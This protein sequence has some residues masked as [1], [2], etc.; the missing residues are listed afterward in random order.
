MADEPAHSHRRLIV[1]DDDPAS[2][3][4]VALAVSASP[5]LTLVGEAPNGMLGAELAERLQPDLVVLDL[6]MP[7]MDG[8][9]ALPLLRQV[10]PSAVVVVRTNRDDVEARQRALGLGAQTVLPKFLGPCELRTILERTRAHALPRALQ[11]ALRRR[12]FVRAPSRAPKP[13]SARRTR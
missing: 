11:D 3:E 1:I 6:E 13:M 7:V 8:F 2:R 9:E 4:L 12:R 10:A 5:E